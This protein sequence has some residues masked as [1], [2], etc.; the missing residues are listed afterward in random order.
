MS[1]STLPTI[2]DHLAQKDQA[3]QSIYLLRIDLEYRNA[4][5]QVLAG[6]GRPEDQSRGWYV[7]PTVLRV[8]ADMEVWTSEI[9]GPVLSVMTFKTEVRLHFQ[10]FPIVSLQSIGILGSLRSLSMRAFRPVPS[11]VVRDATDRSET[12]PL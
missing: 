1:P 7:Q 10:S 8:R 9:F 3:N 2:R 4:Y 6:G 5:C 12:S 11:V